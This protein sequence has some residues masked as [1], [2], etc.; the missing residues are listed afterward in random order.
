MALFLSKGDNRRPA[1]PP[2][3]PDSAPRPAP[4]N[5]LAWTCVLAPG[6]VP[7]PAVPRRL[8]ELAV[9]SNGKD[10][11][12]QGTLGL[13]LY[14][15]GKDKEAITHLEEAVKLAAAPWTPWDCINEALAG[16][17]GA[18]EDRFVLAMAH[19][20]LGHKKEAEEW[21]RKGVALIDAK[22]K[23]P[24]REYGPRLGWQQKLEWQW[25]REEAEAAIKE[26][27]R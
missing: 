6:G 25:L 14:R 10:P 13:A 20:R 21:L 8:A 27:K 19:A 12:W 24:G 5:A 15:C 4:A 26:G 17:R 3:A 11:S 1:K 23:A 22:L 16:L 2:T 18:P 9:A 7:D